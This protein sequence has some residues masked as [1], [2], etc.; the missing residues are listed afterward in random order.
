MEESFYQEHIK[1]YPAAVSGTYRR[2]KWTILAIWLGLYYLLPFI[3]WDRGPGL[4]SQAV[5]VDMPGRRL[6]FFFI[7]IWPQEVYYLTGLLILSAMTL[8]LMTALAGRVWCGYLCWQT[9]WTDLFLGVERLIEGDRRD[10]IKLDEGPT[11]LEKISKKVAK[12]LAWLGIAAGTGGAAVLYFGDAPTTIVEVFT[13]RASYST[14]MWIGIL[15]FTT[16]FFAGYMREQ[17]CIYACPWPRIQAALT[18]EYALNVTYR[19]DRGEPRASVKEGKKLKA[20]GAP[21]GDCVDCYQCVAVC[22]TG[23]DIRMGSQLSCIQCGL[24]IDA[25]DSIMKKLG[26][27]ERLVAYD[28]PLNFDR[29]RAGL[30]PVFKLLRPRT[31]LYGGIIAVIATLM[32]YTFS[33]R[34]LESVNVLH[35]RNPQFVVNSDGSVRNGYTVRFLNRAHKRRDM[36]LSVE[37]MPAGTRIDAIGIDRAID[38]NPVVEIESDRTREVRVS[39]TAPG[40]GFKASSDIVFRITDP[41]DKMTATAKDFFKAP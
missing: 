29:R 1:V 7:E 26:R 4:P 12:W 34:T 13:G 37:G 40:A 28:T 6:Y 5:L 11:N 25:C 30:E 39:V 22:P 14:Y 35:D 36:V 24:C 21:V 41:E 19:V 38:G 33:N 16:Y 15:T 31:M 18:D 3:R 2:I 23:T 20:A 8:F 17:V 27:E 32:V 10:R 9:I